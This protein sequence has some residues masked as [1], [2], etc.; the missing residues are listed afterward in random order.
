[1]IVDKCGMGRGTPEEKAQF[2]MHVREKVKPII[3]N[4]QSNTANALKK[5][6]LQGKLKNCFTF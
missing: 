1:L 5:H 2:W 4:Y 3:N 6:I